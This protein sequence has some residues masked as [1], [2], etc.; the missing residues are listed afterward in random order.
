MNAS[1]HGSYTRCFA[2]KKINKPII[3]PDNKI[4]LSREKATNP[5]YPTAT[6]S[7]HST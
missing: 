5:S 6:Y 7:K 4:D 3:W 2:I 1:A